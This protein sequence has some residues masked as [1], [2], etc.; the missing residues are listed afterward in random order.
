MGY[1]TILDLEKGLDN[2][3]QFSQIIS[4]GVKTLDKLGELNTLAKTLNLETE[5]SLVETSLE[6]ILKASPCRNEVSLEF[7]PG[8]GVIL[9]IINA[10]KRVIQWL[11]DKIRGFLTWASKIYL[12]SQRRRNA[13]KASLK[14]MLK[15]LDKYQG[16]LK[17]IWVM[18]SQVK[19]FEVNG[20]V[21]TDFAR[22]VKE[23]R[24]FMTKHRE[25]TYQRKIREL[26][27]AT[28]LKEFTPEVAVMFYK[29]VDQLVYDL[30]VSVT[31][32]TANKLPNGD[33]YVQD[34]VGNKNVVYSPADRIDLKRQ[35]NNYG[36]RL[37][38]VESQPKDDQLFDYVQ[39]TE[40]IQHLKNLQDLVVEVDAYETVS[41]EATDAQERMVKNLMRYAKQV[42]KLDPEEIT[43]DYLNL[44]RE[45]VISV[46]VMVETTAPFLM[47][48]FTL[49]LTIASTHTTFLEAVTSEVSK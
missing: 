31:L 24:D 40:I 14:A 46:N 34:L 20:S 17:P 3:H 32:R 43:Q 29:R 39:Q 11:I 28:D 6:A 15:A 33:Y 45:A 35:D 16:S 42:D 21:R 13:I 49:G 37:E 27:K 25:S 19:F 44:M 38:N 47:G 8:S 10:I 7:L 12:Q 1:A 48:L 36:Y 18:G 5:G 26:I 4:D 22:S 9:K 2:R 23:L 41:K 30:N